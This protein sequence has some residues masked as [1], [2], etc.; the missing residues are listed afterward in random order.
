MTGT[1]PNRTPV[2]ALEHT[3]V[4][5]LPCSH[6]S[7]ARR[8]STVRCNIMQTC[9]ILLH[10]IGCHHMSPP[11]SVL[12]SAAVRSYEWNV[13]LCTL[14]EVS[15]SLQPTAAACTL[16]HFDLVCGAVIRYCSHHLVAVKC[17]TPMYDYGK[18]VGKMQ[19]DSYLSTPP[20]EQAL[21]YSA[22]NITMQCTAQKWW[23]LNS[24]HS[25]HF[26]LRASLNSA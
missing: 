11:R 2:I 10:L 22:A 23:M 7:A 16:N 20:D 26:K 1:F 5:F 6:Y 3:I 24:G 21:Q 12:H 18:Y 4:F 13:T 19:C 8:C 14:N 25:G 17:V 9:C 15:T